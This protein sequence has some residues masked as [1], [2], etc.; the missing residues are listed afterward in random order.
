[1]SNGIAACRRLRAWLSAALLLALCLP[2]WAAGPPVDHL[3]VPGPLQL[4]GTG[5]ALAWSDAK[6]PSF[7]RQ[8]YLPEGQTLERYRQMLLLD[9]LAI[10]AVPGDVAGHMLQQ[11]R[12]RKQT[13]S[14][15]N[16]DLIVNQE[17]GGVLLD[18]V[19]SGVVA[20][21]TPIVEW[22][23]Y[24]YEAAPGGVLVLGISRRGYGAEDMRRFLADELKGS[25]Q[26]WIDELAGLEMPAISPP[27][28]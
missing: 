23:A 21:G 16:Y 19:M 11:L 2:G 3:S 24:R 22:N 17:T 6:P 4:D 27:Q 28:P 1:M 13:D 10:E 5:F 8:E 18:F 25:R 7:Y 15:V 12:Q 20:D 26:A 14:F 9:Y